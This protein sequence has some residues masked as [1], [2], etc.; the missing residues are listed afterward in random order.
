M[1]GR[2]LGV[3]C[4]TALLGVVA[5]AVSSRPADGA[6]PGRN[7]RIVFATDRSGPSCSR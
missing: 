2:Q 1:T 4:A 7:G 5:L 3:A 6:F